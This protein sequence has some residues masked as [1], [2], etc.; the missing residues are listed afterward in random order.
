[1]PKGMEEWTSA[2]NQF[3]KGQEDFKFFLRSIN[4]ALDGG[5]HGA[6]AV[7]KG[8]LRFFIASNRQQLDAELRRSTKDS[9]VVNLGWS[10][11]N[12]GFS[13]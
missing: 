5:L 4:E 6:L 11:V 13:E 7:N 12:T 2:S 1:M 3:L 8:S 9:A 10:M